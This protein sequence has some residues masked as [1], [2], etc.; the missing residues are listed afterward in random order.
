MKKL[1][2]NILFCLMAL[3]VTSC[4][5]EVT[6][7]G[8]AEK[9]K[10]M[11]LYTFDKGDVNLLQTV[12][13]DPET[14]TYHLLARLP[15]NG[16]YLLGG[17]KSALFPIYLKGG[18]QV[19]AD[20]KDNHLTLAGNEHSEENRALF[21]WED[22]VNKIKLD[23]FLHQY[24]PGEYSVEYDVFFKELEE[25]SAYQATLL[26]E[27]KNKPGK[28]YA[29]LR[30][31]I[32]T[33]LPFYALAY[34]RGKGG[35]PD[36]ISLSAYYQQTPFD[37]TF[38][39]PTIIDLPYVRKMLETYV[40]FLHKDKGIVNKRET[41][42]PIEHLKDKL[43]QQ[44][45]LLSEASQLKFYDEYQNLLNQVGEDFFT[46]Q[47]QQRLQT[48][49]ARLAWSKPGL[50]APEFKAMKPDSTWISLSDYKGKVVVVDVWATWCEPC[51][52]MM[53]LFKQL[54]EEMKGEN[55]AFLSVC[56]GVW[57]ETD[58]WL[59]MSKQFQ[60]EENTSFVNGWNSD[61]VKSYHISGVPRYMIF[62]E[63]GRIVSVS[64]PNP[65]TPKLKE[66]I[67]KTLH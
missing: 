50:P 30:K 3:V 41:K 14:N 25:L 13:V 4:S 18:E 15:Y 16:L 22:K 66:L 10:E 2:A 43:L 60:I 20:Y 31:K 11:S 36:S 28:F 55:I 53:P 1:I 59:E 29:F 57:V 7:S 37:E 35:V 56:V 39:D 33:D 40:W 26:K 12:T 8:M 6:I 65:T 51:K 32:E 42:Y 34:L 5:K 46:P 17:N 23:A 9:T 38:Q 21:Q 19:S 62:D 54:E 49:E 64:A 48:I 61:F 44:E 47:Y 63:E 67:E 24:L 52:R 27:L 45:Y 58:K